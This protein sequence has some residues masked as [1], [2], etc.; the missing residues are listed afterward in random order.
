MQIL[1]LAAGTR[2]EINVTLDK[3]PQ[4]W[5]M[6]EKCSD[7]RSVARISC[8]KN[9]N[10]NKISLKVRALPR[11]CSEKHANRCT[12]LNV[13][14]NSFGL[15]HEI[16]DDVKNENGEYVICKKCCMDQCPATCRGATC[17]KRLRLKVKKSDIS[18]NSTINLQLSGTCEL[19]VDDDDN[20]TET[21]LLINYE[22]RSWIK[23]LQHCKDLNTTLVQITNDTVGEDVVSL[24]EERPELQDGVW[25][26]L[27]RS[28][29]GTDTE[30]KW[31]SGIRAEY[32]VWKSSSSVD[33]LNNHCGKLVWLEESQQTQLLDGDCHQRLPFL[34]HGLP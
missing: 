6:K 3:C 32:S 31:T 1:H 12:C 14:V 25:I 24:L 30:W 20:E 19:R 15:S 29:F 34:C 21:S 18:S 13:T 16:I 22:A 11:K 2:R 17:K 28:I 10:K 7:E 5:I 9:K 8:W 4:R 26:G 23:A 27:E 33:P